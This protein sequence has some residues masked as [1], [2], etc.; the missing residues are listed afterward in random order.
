MLSGVLL[1]AY[2]N[3]YPFYFASLCAE[4]GNVMPASYVLFTAISAVPAT[5]SISFS[6]NPFYRM[7]CLAIWLVYCLI[8]LVFVLESF[9][10]VNCYRDLGGS[11]VI[12]F[13][14]LCT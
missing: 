13:I 11:Q 10:N 12:C 1:Y 7:L 2:F 5:V 14:G 8:I 9:V 4:S 6:Y 3:W